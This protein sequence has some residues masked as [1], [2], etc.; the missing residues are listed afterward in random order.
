M[1]KSSKKDDESQRQ[2]LKMSS[3]PTLSNAEELLNVDT[4]VLKQE[5]L[6]KVYEKCSVE[7]EAEQVEDGEGRNEQ[8]DAF[9]SLRHFH[10]RDF[11]CSECSRSDH[12]QLQSF[13]RQ[14]C[15]RRRSLAPW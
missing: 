4:V 15:I 1:T 3:P 10:S 13:I 12:H 11:G 2:A 5:Q 7:L 8:I 6:E 9:K 14:S